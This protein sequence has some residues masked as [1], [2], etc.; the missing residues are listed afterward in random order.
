[1]LGLGSK[2]GVAGFVPPFVVDGAADTGSV[3]DRIWEPTFGTRS[4][5]QDTTKMVVGLRAYATSARFMP[6]R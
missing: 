1:M 3:S 4:R 2:G 6:R 5:Q